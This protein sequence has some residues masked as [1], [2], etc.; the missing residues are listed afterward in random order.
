MRTRVHEYGGGAWRLVGA[1][2][3]VF[4][5]FA[6]QRLYRQRLGRGAG[7]DLARAAEQ[8]GALRYADM[9]P[10]PDGARRRLRAR[11]RRRAANR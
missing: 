1:D 2:L 7:G 3:V 4:V 11:T 5:D 10:T 6:D 9:R 8:P